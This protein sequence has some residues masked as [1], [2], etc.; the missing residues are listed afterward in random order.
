M[1]LDV[2]FRHDIANILR[3]TACASEAS[4]GLFVELIGDVS[5]A[6]QEKLARVH[7][8]AVRSTLVALGLAFGLEPVGPGAQMRPGTS[9]PLAGLLWAEVPRER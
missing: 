4:T 7:R 8:Q 6:E 1:G 9:P 5:T 3:A 2:Y